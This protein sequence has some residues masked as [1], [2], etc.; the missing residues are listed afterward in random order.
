MFW[1]NQ[2]YFLKDV[3]LLFREDK[4]RGKVQSKVPGGSQGP[5]SF[6]SLVK[7]DS[8]TAF[9]VTVR[10]PGV[11][12]RFPRNWSTDV[13]IFDFKTRAM[14]HN[15]VELRSKGPG[16]KGNPPIREMISGPICHFPI[17]FYIGY[18]G[19]SVYGKN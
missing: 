15:T 12:I 11:P 4:H 16:S 10:T 5:L 1:K 2:D 9:I 3:H 19:I 14:I 18:K 17:Y 7:R 8:I 13:K 6:C